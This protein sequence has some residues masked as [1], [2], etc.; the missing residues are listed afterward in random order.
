MR[1]ARR[2]RARRRKTIPY[3]HE[4]ARQRD[5]VTDANMLSCAQKSRIHRDAALVDQDEAERIASE[6]KHA[7][8]ERERAHL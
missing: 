2:D 1:S 8:A 7:V 3:L 6:S 4:V 5:D